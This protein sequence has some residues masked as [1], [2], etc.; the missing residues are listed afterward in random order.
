MPD[1]QAQMAA[2]ERQMKVGGLVLILCS[3]SITALAVITSHHMDTSL[4]AAIGIFASGICTFGVTIVW[5]GRH[6]LPDAF[7][8][9]AVSMAAT[10]AIAVYA[11]ADTLLIGAVA[12]AALIG[13][14]VG[15]MLAWLDRLELRQMHL[16]NELGA[17]EHA[18][19]ASNHNPNSGALTSAEPV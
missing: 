15:I 19:S 13:L 7:A 5:T 1:S 6:G 11:A 9:G 2:V 8:A 16:Q 14:G 10:S 18:A 12:A 17:A 3:F 4:L